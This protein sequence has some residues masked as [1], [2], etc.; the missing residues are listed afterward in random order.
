MSCCLNR[1]PGRAYFGE[2]VSSGANLKER[3]QHQG[4][5]KT[6]SDQPVRRGRKDR[7]RT[8]NSYQRISQEPMR[9][10]NEHFQTNLPNFAAIELFR[11]SVKQIEME[12]STYC[13][14][15][16]SY[17][18]NSVIDRRHSSDYMS[19]GLFN[20]ILSQL[21]S[22]DFS[23][24]LH[25]H[26][27]N[28]PLANKEYILSR[29]SKTRQLLP[30]A[31]IGIFTN[32]DYLDRTYLDKLYEAGCRSL[33]ATLQ[34]EGSKYDTPMMFN[35]L[36]DRVLKLG[37]EFAIGSTPGPI[38]ASVKVK[39]MTF[40]YTAPDRSVNER[41]YMFGMNRGESL[42]VNMAFRR[43][44][45]CIVPFMEMQI[46]CDGTL[47]PCCNLRSDIPSHHNCVLGRLDETSN[48]FLEWSNAC[49]VKWRKML[50][51]HGLK[52]SPCRSCNYI[53]QA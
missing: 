24:I 18:P 26:R 41:G 2:T 34:Y 37:Y 20:N 13:N 10:F 38:T 31:S 43:T 19:D 17:C 51:S 53:V 16:C 49:Y 4:N 7:E 6:H 25:F 8:A 40:I 9:V 35:R 29:I 33:Q 12:L 1:R 5:Q 30:K 14:R 22:I 48:I 27:Y 3:R 21:K 46:E 50:I 11:Q 44:S 23:G 39:D 42:Q 47:L 15:A 28:E 45:P 32:G 36:K 52:D